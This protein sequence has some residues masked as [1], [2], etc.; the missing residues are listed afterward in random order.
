MRVSKVCCLVSKGLG[1]HLIWFCVLSSVPKTPCVV[2][3]KLSAP[4]LSVDSS[5]NIVPASPLLATYCAFAFAMLGVS[6]ETNSRL[7]ES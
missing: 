4:T 2:P 7:L 3:T 6:Y 5:Q 1:T